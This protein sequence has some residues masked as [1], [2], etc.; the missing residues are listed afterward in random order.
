M[1]TLLVKFA[2]AAGL[3]L[4]VGAVSAAARETQTVPNGTGKFMHNIGAIGGRDRVYL[5]YVPTNLKPGAPLLI[6][7]HGGGG[8]GPMARLGTG[9]VYDQLAD[10]DGFLVVYPYGIAMSWNTCRKAQSNAA[11]RWEVDDLGFVEA[12]IEQS[13]RSY[14]IDRK[15][16]FATGHSNGGQISYRLMLERPDLVAG[17]AAVSSNLPAEG[18]M[19]CVPK[20]VPTPVMTINGTADPVALYNGGQRSGGTNGPSRST[21]ATM[22]YFTKL[23]GQDG[24]PDVTR[25]PHVRDNDP[26]WVERTAWTQPGK[27]PVILYTIHGG[28]HVVPQPFYRYPRNVGRMTEDLN[29][30]AVIWEFFSKLPPRD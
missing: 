27:P 30:P 3:S 26:T 19:D 21:D 14:G 12:I 23:N 24:E 8:D 18:N 1:T 29:A 17:V 9:G 28:G 13:A 5:T 10:R 25:L 11:R 20:N 6:M 16:V 4:I 2:A 7:F 22:E 15:R